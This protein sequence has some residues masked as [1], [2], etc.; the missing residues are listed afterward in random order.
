MKNYQ[1]KLKLKDSQRN[2]QGHYLITY[3]KMGE[4]GNVLIPFNHVIF[5]AID[6][7]V[8]KDFINGLC[9]EQID[10]IEIKTEE[11]NLDSEIK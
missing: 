8:M 5:T 2:E 11:N 7:E 1:I 6:F 4:L 3:S 9:E 10:T